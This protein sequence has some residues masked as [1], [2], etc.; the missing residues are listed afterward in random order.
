MRFFKG[1]LKYSLYVFIAAWMF[2]L[3]IMV[4]RGN[5]P[6]KFDTQKFQKRLETI[7]QD[8]GAQKKVPEK[9]DLKFYDVLDRPEIEE[10]IVL[11]NKPVK[12]DKEEIFPQKEVFTQ[13]S[14]PLKTSK[15]KKT[16]KNGKVKIVQ[17]NRLEIKQSLIN[18]D[19]N[20]ANNKDQKKSASNI[21]PK[22]KYTVQIAAYKN[23]KDAVSQGVVLQKKGF[24][25]YRVKGQKD[26]ETWYRVRSGSFANFDEAKKFKKKLDRLKV[27]SLIIKL[28]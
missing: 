8:F 7:A 5:S 16:L 14:I 10:V 9:I 2:V 28:D 4:G 22:G 19:N 26:G 21:P 25:S 24:S 15:K 12:G 20:E 11:D 23:F 1:I 18:K 17:K 13:E 3:G 6:V 27:N